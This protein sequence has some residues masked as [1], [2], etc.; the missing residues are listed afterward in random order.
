MASSRSCP[1]FV[2]DTRLGSSSFIPLATWSGVGIRCSCS[3]SVTRRA[4][5]F[6]EQVIG[7][8]A[9]ILL[10]TGR[11]GQ[12][13][14]LGFGRH[15]RVR[16]S[17]IDE[18]AEH[19]MPVVEQ[20]RPLVVRLGKTPAAVRVVGEL[21]IVANQVAGAGIGGEELVAVIQIGRPQVGAKMG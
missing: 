10:L 17:E 2:R 16:R 18:L 7:V 9:R 8:A 21:Q 20:P 1:A 6:V 11:E 15:A 19:E 14:P 3:H 12:L 13:A 5:Y 4:S